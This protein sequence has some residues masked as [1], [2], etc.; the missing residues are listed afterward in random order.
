MQSYHSFIFV[1]F[2]IVQYITI[3]RFNNFQSVQFHALKYGLIIV[4][5]ACYLIFSIT[6]YPLY[7]IFYLHLPPPP[8]MLGFINR[9]MDVGACD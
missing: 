8:N 1:H 4:Q 2:Y 6:M 3:S 5:L 9:I 7:A